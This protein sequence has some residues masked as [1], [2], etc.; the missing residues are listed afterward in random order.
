M[1][2]ALITIGLLTTISQV[3][4]AFARGGGIHSEDLWNPQLPGQPGR[5]QLFVGEEPDRQ[6]SW[7][8]RSERSPKRITLD[9]H[10]SFTDLTQRSA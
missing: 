2:L 4:P 7:A 6:S 1:K 5:R 3:A 8:R 10:S 9:R